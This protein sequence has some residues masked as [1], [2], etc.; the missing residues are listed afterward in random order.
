MIRTNFEIIKYRYW[1][2]RIFFTMWFTYGSFYLCRVNYSVAQPGILEEF[3]WTKTEVGFIT[4]ALLGAYA[5]GQFI[6]GALGDKFGAKKMIFLG[7]LVSASIN[8]VFGFGNTLLLF[9][10]LWGLNGYFQAMGWPLS[11]K[12]LGNWFFP[13]QRGTI[14]GLWGT[15]YQFGN[16]ICWFLAGL[17]IQHLSWRWSFWIHSVIFVLFAIHFLL[18]IKESPQEVSLKNFY[19][20]NLTT[21]NK[22]VVFIIKNTLSSKTIWIIAITYL[23]LGFIRYGFLTWAI[24]YLVESCGCTIGS[25]ALKMTFLPF[26]GCLGAILAGRFSDTLF[27]TRRAPMAT[28]MLTCLAIFIVL[29]KIISPKY[30]FF[31]LICIGIIGFTIYGTDCLL[32]GPAA[33]DF[34]VNKAISTSA[35]F[36]D[37]MM[38]VGAIFSGLGVGLLVDNFGWNAAIYSWVALSLFA[39]LLISVLWNKKMDI[40]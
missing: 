39:G 21:S 26:A 12:T 10:L 9:I 15:C 6:N 40:R 5:L 28:I 11:I 23:C 1:R 8:M 20:E 4:S 17:I 25:S 35:G 31:N 13:K 18:R 14:M 24:T 2:R 29:F 27:Q 38:Y 3:N 30:W 7:M 34:A 16:F 37:G 33:Q 19:P 22:N 32:G 36:I